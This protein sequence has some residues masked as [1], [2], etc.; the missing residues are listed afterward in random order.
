M[1]SLWVR[2]VPENTMNAIR[3]LE[4]PS[5]LLHAF[6]HMI[7]SRLGPSLRGIDRWMKAQGL[8]HWT[9]LSLTTDIVEGMVQ[10]GKDYV[11][12]D[13]GL[14]CGVL[15]QGEGA[16]PSELDY[17]K[18]KPISV[19][20]NLACVGELDELTS[21]RLASSEFSPLFCGSAQPACHRATE[22]AILEPDTDTESERKR[23]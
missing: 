2:C 5:T 22:A 4:M 21:L 8:G 9:Y 18:D 14:R 10:G 11:V 15:K 13:S 19:H 3:L 12:I 16:K 23:A 6:R 7:P 1:S 17:K 20:L